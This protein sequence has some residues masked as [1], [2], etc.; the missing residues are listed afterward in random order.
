MGLGSIFSKA[1][2]FIPGVGP[3]LS[4]GADALGAVGKANAQNQGNQISA[5]E[6]QAMLANSTAAQ[7]DASRNSA[8]KDLMR[9]DYVMNNNNGYTPATLKS[10][11][12][13]V[14]DHQLPSFGIARQPFTSQA[15]LGAAGMANEADNRLRNGPQLSVPNLT[16]MAQPSTW[17]KIL[18]V[19]APAAKVA[20]TFNWGGNQSNPYD[21]ATGDE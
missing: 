7:N 20:S 17:Q 8:W 4:M 18:N 15:V 9:A 21:Y 14:A 16:G 1:L 12:P 6:R 5:A 19:A 13:G 11:V 2:S 3:L 10:N